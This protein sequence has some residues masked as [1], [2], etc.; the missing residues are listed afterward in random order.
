MKKYPKHIT[1]SEIVEKDDL[2]LVFYLLTKANHLVGK[3]RRAVKISFSNVEHLKTVKSYLVQLSALNRMRVPDEEV[4]EGIFGEEIEDS[5]EPLKNNA[6]APDHIMELREHDLM[7]YTRVT[8]D[9]DIRVGLWYKV[10]LFQGELILEPRPDIV[11]R[12]DPV[13]LAFDIETTKLPLKFPDSS[14]DSVMMISYMIDGVGFLIT[15]REIVSQNIDDFEYT[16]KPEYQGLFHIFN[17]KNEK[18]TIQRFF[19]HIKT[20]K[21]TVFVTYNGDFFDWPF[22]S[23][24]A[25]FHG[26]DMYNVCFVYNFRKLVSK[27]MLVENFWLP[28]L[29]TWIAFTG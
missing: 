5:K 22:I 26:I 3:K 4:Y 14:F 17:E 25:T 21:P 1:S 9:Q 20:V 23:A 29:P 12:A 15:N 24:R 16:P 11:R 27:R 10:S 8:I 19:N 28:M 6:Q 2:D 7:Y 18:D 13:V